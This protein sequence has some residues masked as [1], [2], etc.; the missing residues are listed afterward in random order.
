[1]IEHINPI[2]CKYLLLTNKL[3][4]QK[5]TG[6]TVLLLI[7]QSKRDMQHLFL[8]NIHAGQ[9][10]SR[11]PSQP[12]DRGGSYPWIKT[13]LI[14]RWRRQ[15]AVSE[16]SL[17]F[18]SLTTSCPYLALHTTGPFLQSAYHCKYQDQLC[19]MLPQTNKKS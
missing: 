15:P 8:H 11:L 6:M 13:P 12:G 17:V 16:C 3:N 14:T 2:L 7:E 10:L 9:K 18:Y 19:S 4:S 1:M 5:T